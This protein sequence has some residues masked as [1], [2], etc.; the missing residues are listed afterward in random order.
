M[1]KVQKEGVV[2]NK[3]HLDFE[4]EGVLNPAVIEENGVI[5]MFYRAVRRGNHSTIGYCQFDLSLGLLYRAIQPIMEVEHEYEQHGVEDPRIT[6]I[7]GRYYLTYTAYDGHNALGALAMSND[8]TSFEKH[9][10][11][12]P[13]LTY[14]EFM[15]LAESKGALNVKYPRYNIP[16]TTNRSD[17]ISY[18]WDKNVI[19][20]PRRISGK[21]HFLHRIKPDIQIVSVTN[22]I[23]LNDDFWK[24]YFLDFHNHIV[25]S[26]KYEHEI[27]YLGGGCTPIETEE[28]WL[29]IYHSVHDTI[30]GFVYCACA[31]LLDLHNPNKELARLPYPLFIPDQ[32]WELKGEVNNVCFPTGAIVHQGLLYIFYGAADEQ[33]ACATV[34]LSTL[35][36]EL[37]LNK[38]DHV[39]H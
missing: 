11:I 2:L 32:E 10:I 21:L 7:D 5:H 20:F 36:A 13:K 31:A 15:V 18:V 30:K 14:K 38:Q 4:N 22:L 29:L 39:K 6:K 1:I 34:N 9:G 12:V 28:G 37:L 3:T 26:P 25:I 23:E 16:N 17:K 24:A 35:I 33:I 19:F 27:S 8:L